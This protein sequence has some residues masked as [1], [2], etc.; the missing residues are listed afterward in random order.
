MTD[1][2]DNDW[3]EEEHLVLVEL[4]GVADDQNFAK[5]KKEC[6]ILGIETEKPVLQVGNSVFQ[7]EYKKAV[8]T[9]VIFEGDDEGKNWKYKC[10]THNK[11]EMKRVF[12]QPKE[13]SSDEAQADAA[14][15]A[16]METEDAKDDT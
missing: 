12:L 4:S 8:G 11:L 10:C 2:H 3:I 1:T 9:I 14:S 16:A 5:S 6:K 7:G 13:T 15:P